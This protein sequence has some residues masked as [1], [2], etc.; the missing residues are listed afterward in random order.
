MT[1]GRRKLPSDAIVRRAHLAGET[2]AQIARRLFT[3]TDV[4][5]LKLQR[6]A[7]A[8]GVAELG[9]RRRY[10]LPKIAYRDRFG[11]EISLPAITMHVRQ[12]AAE[13]RKGSPPQ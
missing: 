10:S 4:I 9:K 1:T 12:L 11:T 3:S 8:A 13:G 6:A 2:P 5:K 7:V